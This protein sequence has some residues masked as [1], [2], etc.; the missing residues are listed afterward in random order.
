SAMKISNKARL[1]VAAAANLAQ[2]QDCAPV[3]LAHLAREH[4]VSVSHVEQ[5]F[6]QLRRHGLV[7]GVRGPGGGYRLAR[8][9]ADIS[10]ALI[11]AVIDGPLYDNRSKESDEGSNLPPTLMNALAKRLHDF[12]GQITLADLARRLDLDNSRQGQT[13]EKMRNLI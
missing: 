6:A 4:H 5:L 2:R 8:P 12:L 9:P 13:P 3:T 10:V 1:A 7:E 11:I